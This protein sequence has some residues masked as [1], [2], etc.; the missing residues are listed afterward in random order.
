MKNLLQQTDEQRH[1][2]IFLFCLENPNQEL[3]RQHEQQN[4]GQG[5]SCPTTASKAET[6][7]YFFLPIPVSFESPPLS[8]HGGSF[9]VCRSK[10]FVKDIHKVLLLEATTPRSLGVSTSLTTATLPHT[11]PSFLAVA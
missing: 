9:R 3:L 10:I 7:C 5:A 11:T 6:S 2:R 8:N 1:M 4:L